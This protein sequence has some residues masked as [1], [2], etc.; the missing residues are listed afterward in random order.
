MAL[1]ASSKVL[2]S[3]FTLNHLSTQMTLL[4]HNS[5]ETKKNQ[6][7]KTK[8]RKIPK[9]RYRTCH[10]IAERLAVTTA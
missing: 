9:F 7:V 6:I 8:T 10:L 4:L 5:Y 2:S 3:Y 1:K